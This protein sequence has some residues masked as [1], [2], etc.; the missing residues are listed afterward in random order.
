MGV[1]V[2]ECFER[3]GGVGSPNWMGR[4]SQGISLGEKDSFWRALCTATPKTSTPFSVD[5]RPLWRLLADLM[6]HSIDTLFW[7]T[8]SD[9]N[10]P[11]ENRLKRKF[12]ELPG[13]AD[14]PPSRN[15]RHGGLRLEFIISRGIS[16]WIA[17]GG[18]INI[19]RPSSA[20][21][22]WITPS[23]T[24]C[25]AD[26]TMSVTGKILVPASQYSCSGL[27]KF[28]RSCRVFNKPSSWHYKQHFCSKCEHRP[29][30]WFVA[31]GSLHFIAF[32][33]NLIGNLNQGQ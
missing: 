20:P 12:E 4:W 1:K 17:D 19:A 13:Q 33:Y 29:Y 16:T 31:F 8:M 28:D 9:P 23:S 32:T 26:I 5:R 15:K 10:D 22:T 21:P 27:L 18:S 30:L 6:P 11:R 24:V 3:M 7:T 2:G 14:R 25:M